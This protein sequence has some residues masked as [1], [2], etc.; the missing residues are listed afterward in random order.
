MWKI[1]WKI[2]YPEKFINTTCSLPKGRMLRVVDRSYRSKYQK[3][4]LWLTA[5]TWPH[6]C[7]M[8]VCLL[9][10]SALHFLQRFSILEA[11]CSSSKNTLSVQNIDSKGFMDIIQEFWYV[12]NCTPVAYN[13]NQVQPLDWFTDDATLLFSLADSAR[14]HRGLHLV[15][16]K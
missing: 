8:T 15:P 5:L 6:S 1:S 9:F 14:K 16:A 10:N 4:L 12:R 7:S 11:G 13:G 3:H 2:D